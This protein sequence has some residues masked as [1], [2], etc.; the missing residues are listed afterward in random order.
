VQ[1]LYD[2][3]MSSETVDRI[4]L[5]AVLEPDEDGWINARV[6]ELPS[7][8][9]CARS[10]EEAKE[11]LADAVRELVASYASEAREAQSDSTRYETLEIDLR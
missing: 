4:R 1:R 3:A 9:T 5:T 2:E 7:A 10:L 8:N 11:M 6:L